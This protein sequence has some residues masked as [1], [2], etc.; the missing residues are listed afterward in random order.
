MKKESQ[1]FENFPKIVDIKQIVDEISQISFS[2]YMKKSKTGFCYHLS[3]IF[4]E[5][6]GTKHLPHSFLPLNGLDLEAYR[7]QIVFS[8]GS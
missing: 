7:G 6:S 2:L 3:P 8:F 1:T 4:L 5:L